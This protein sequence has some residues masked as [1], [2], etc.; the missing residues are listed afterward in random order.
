[1]SDEEL[2]KA[3]FFFDLVVKSDHIAEQSNEH[4][5]KKIYGV[6]TLAS[7][8]IPLVFGLGYFVLTQTKEQVIFF[9]IFVSLVIFLLAMARGILL[10]KPKWFLYVDVLDA[11]NKY[12]GESLPYIINKSAV[13]WADTINHNH[14]VINSREKGISQMLILITLGFI[15]LVVTFLALGISMMI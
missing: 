12:K 6:L 13:T 10:L 14:S 8:L 4:V 9:P 3:Q 11:I 15:V 2:K 7:G 5:L 1:M